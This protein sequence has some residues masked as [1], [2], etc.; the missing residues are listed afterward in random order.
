MGLLLRS[1]GAGRLFGLNVPLRGVGPVELE[2]GMGPE[3]A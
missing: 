2:G 3:R 1:E